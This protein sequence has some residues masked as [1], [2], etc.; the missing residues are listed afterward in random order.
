QSP[1]LRFAVHYI[2]NTPSSRNP[3]LWSHPRRVNAK[4]P[5]TG[6]SQPRKSCFS[7][8]RRLISC[9]LQIGA[10]MTK[11]TLLA[12]IALLAGSAAAALAQPGGNGGTATYWM[13]A[14]TTSGMA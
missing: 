14:E 13:S 4:R 7:N 5:L 8:Q 2:H 3:A 10:R 11:T 1:Y 9:T 12:G 6:P